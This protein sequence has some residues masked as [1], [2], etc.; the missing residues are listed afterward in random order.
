MLWG[1]GLAAE[2][3]PDDLP[4]EVRTALALLL[5]DEVSAAMQVAEVFFEELCEQRAQ[6][7]LAENCDFSH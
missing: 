5:S 7:E 2:D 1:Y 6:A 4:V 3:M